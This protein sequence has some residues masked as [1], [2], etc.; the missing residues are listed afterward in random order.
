MKGPGTTYTT[1]ETVKLLCKSIITR[2]E[3]LKII[4][5]DAGQRQVVLDEL[6]SMIGPHVVSEED[7][8]IRTIEKMGG[9]AEEL[10]YA[11]VTESSQFRTA[12]GMLR[13]EI[14]ENEL[15]GLYFQQ[16]LKELATQVARHLMASKQIDEVYESD[17][18]IER[19]VVDIIHKF[20][21]ANLH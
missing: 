8:R 15:N 12:R 4:E 2:L 13:K 10:Q 3:N 18:E 11:G 1:Q 9:K 14:G 20:N 6:F 5:F 16:T 17:Q 7:L 19:R 21:P